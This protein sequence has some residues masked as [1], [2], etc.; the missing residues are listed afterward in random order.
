MVEDRLRPTHSPR[1]RRLVQQ[2]NVGSPTAQQTSTSPN[3]IHTDEPLTTA[4]DPVQ[5]RRGITTDSTMILD[6]PRVGRCKTV[7]NV[8]AMSTRAAVAI[9]YSQSIAYRI[10]AAST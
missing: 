7:L 4:T 5:L 8:S 2:C 3:K 10:A 6:V 1:R 9:C